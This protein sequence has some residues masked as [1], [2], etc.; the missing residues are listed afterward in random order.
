MGSIKRFK[1]LAL[2]AAAACLAFGCDK[3]ESP[4]QPPQDQT[5]PRVEWVAPAEQA[6]LSGIET[7]IVKVVDDG[8]VTAVHFSKNGV[9]P[10]SNK[11]SGHAD[12]LYTLVWDT[13]N[14]ADGAYRFEV[15]A[16]DNAGNWG[17]SQ[18][19]QFQVR[20][21]LPATVLLVAN[22]AGGAGNMTI[23]DITTGAMQFGAA[24]LGNVPNDI[25]RSGSRLFVIN[26]TSNDMNVLDI[27]DRNE[28][29]PRRTVDLGVAKGLRPQY[30]A[31]ADNGVLFI[32]NL[33]DNTVTMLDTARMIPL[34]YIPVGLSP[35][36]VLAYGGK[37]YVC[38]SGYNP[39]TRSYDP[40]SVMVISTITNRVTKTISVG[41]NPQF[42]AM[43]DG[44]IHVVCTGN[45]GD[46]AG[47]IYKIDVTGD[48]LVQ[49]INI[50]GTPGDIAITGSLAYVAAGGWLT[51][52]EVYR[53]NAFTGQILNGPRNPILV[54]TGA[55]RVIAARDGSVF[56]A[57]FSG[58][59]VDEIV[60][61]Q[62]TAS[63]AVGDEPGAMALIE[64]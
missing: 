38:N 52:G 16:W 10:D 7:L 40:G 1:W 64:R 5:V 53:Y 2:L 32:S 15:R 26:S 27:S 63:Y 54:S 28:L 43:D 21:S 45:Y 42:M 24:G 25:V 9:T 22:A 39:Q 34:G 47:E 13:R 56:V 48:T 12:S 44:K 51:N 31:L 4:V 11:F 41:T 3:K 59:R 57:C 55:M 36:D 8:A 33:S 29:S 30:A 20:N 50:G 19:R 6:E 35:A 62:S 61:A 17:T 23:V 37:V 18:V 58:D 46:I 49:V 14:D 60:G